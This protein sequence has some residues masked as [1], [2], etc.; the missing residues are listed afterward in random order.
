MYP[1]S[2]DL[3]DVEEIAERGDNEDDIEEPGNESEGVD[4]VFSFYSI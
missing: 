2:E 1:P 3:E 4:E